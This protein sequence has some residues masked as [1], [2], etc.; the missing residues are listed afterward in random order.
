MPTAICL[1]DLDVNVPFG[2]E[3]YGTGLCVLFKTGRAALGHPAPPE[4]MIEVIYAR[5]ILEIIHTGKWLRT[6]SPVPVVVRHD[7]DG[8]NSIDKALAQSTSDQGTPSSRGESSN[9][10]Q[11]GHVIWLRL[12]TVHFGFK[13]R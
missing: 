4:E 1:G 8:R 6:N 3:G 13:G 2:E 9:S 11:Q 7:V 10:L 5:E 12:Q